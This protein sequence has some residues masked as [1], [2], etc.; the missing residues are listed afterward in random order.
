MHGFLGYLEPPQRTVNPKRRYRKG[1]LPKETI[2]ATRSWTVAL[3]H[4][5]TFILKGLDLH[6]IRSFDSTMMRASLRMLY[7]ICTDNKGT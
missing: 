2:S 6:H 3:A 5:L 1:Y 4:S 7:A